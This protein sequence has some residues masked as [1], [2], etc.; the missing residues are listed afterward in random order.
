MP[1][2]A[3]R[4]T[5]LPRID[6]IRHVDLSAGTADDLAPGALAEGLSFEALTLDGQ[7]LSAVRITECAFN[8]L[9][10]SETIFRS[11]SF[12]DCTIEQLNAPVFSAP[13]SRFTDVSIDRSRLGSADLYDTRWRSVSVAHSKLGFIN[14][15]GSELV[16]VRFE[17]CTIDELD[18]AS[19]KLERVQFV[20]CRVGVLSLTGATLSNADLRGLELNQIDGIPFLKGATISDLQ[21]SLLAPLFADH[22]GI[23]VST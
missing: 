7:N 2:S 3:S 16:D 13:R 9:S 11:A 10:A 5:F 18:L 4:R 1:S 17:S 6:P 19:A 21:M 22:L 8:G 12:S 23:K 20:D 14:L 15:R